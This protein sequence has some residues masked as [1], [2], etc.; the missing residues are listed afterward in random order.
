MDTLFMYSGKGLIPQG[1]Q[2]PLNFISKLA[3]YMDEA[4]EEHLTLKTFTKAVTEGDAILKSIRNGKQ[5]IKKL[6]DRISAY[7]TENVLGRKELRKVPLRLWAKAAAEGDDEG[8]LPC[9]HGQEYE[10]CSDKEFKKMT[11]FVQALIQDDRNRGYGYGYGRGQESQ[12]PPPQPE[13][14]LDHQ[15]ELDQEELDQEE[16]ELEE[17]D[18]EEEEEYEEDELADDLRSD[19]PEHHR[20]ERRLL[21]ERL[22][23]AQ[24]E[25]EHF[26]QQELQETGQVEVIGSGQSMSPRTPMEEI[27]DFSLDEDDEADAEGEDEVEGVKLKT[28]TQSLGAF[29]TCQVLLWMKEMKL[30]M[31]ILMN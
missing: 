1:Y 6:Y 15:E 25:L 21:Q 13:A 23:Q 30:P 3:S 31:L 27:P 5:K 16:Q 17:E 11:D 14:A 10:D 20:E 29:G 2:D 26:R 8:P 4:N 28:L 24:Q 19:G 22:K 7:G 12:L 18:Q 9:D